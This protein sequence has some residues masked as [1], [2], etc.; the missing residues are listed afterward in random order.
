MGDIADMMLDGTLDYITGEYMGGDYGYPRTNDEETL[1]IL[2]KK[3]IHKIKCK[4]CG[5]LLHPDGI[6]QHNN[7][8]HK[9]V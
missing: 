3:S 5:K 7:A 2:N 9:A 6:R 1:K 4:I 8:K